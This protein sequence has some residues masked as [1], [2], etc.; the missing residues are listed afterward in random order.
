MKLFEKLKYNTNQ[1]VILAK[2]VTF[3]NGVT[4]NEGT[5]VKIVG[6]DNIFKTYDIVYNGEIYTDFSDSDFIPGKDEDR[7]I[8]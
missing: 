2:T 3:P 6:K 1:F 7:Y 4:I 8:Q 5:E